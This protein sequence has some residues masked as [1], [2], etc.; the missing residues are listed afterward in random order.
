M[1]DGAEEF[2]VKTFEEAPGL[3]ALRHRRVTGV[4][5]EHLPYYTPADY[6]ASVRL[7]AGILRG[8]EGK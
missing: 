7:V 6:L 2:F 1:M 3:S 5:T 8:G 4:G